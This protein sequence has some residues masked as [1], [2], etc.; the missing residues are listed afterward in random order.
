MGGKYT[1]AQKKASM[2]YQKKL[3]SISIRLQPEDADRYKQAA[4]ECGMSLREFVLTAMDEKIERE[5]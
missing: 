1:E 5:K 2:E 3:A 4:A